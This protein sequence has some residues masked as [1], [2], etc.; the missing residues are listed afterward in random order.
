MKGRVDTIWKKVESYQERT[1]SIQDVDTKFW[2]AQ[3]EQ[4]ITD[5]I[6]VIQDLPPSEICKHFISGESEGNHRDYIDLHVPCVF[7]AQCSPEY[8]NRTINK[9]IKTSKVLKEL[10]GTLK[11][12]ITC[13]FTMPVSV[14]FILLMSDEIMNREAQ[15]WMD[16]RDGRMAKKPK[17]ETHEFVED[18]RINSSHDFPEYD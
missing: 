13:V 2:W 11:W 6:E 1:V 3:I 18:N 7:P 14:R 5:A 10:F 8:I 4:N 17:P 12:N 16:L 15:R 9:W